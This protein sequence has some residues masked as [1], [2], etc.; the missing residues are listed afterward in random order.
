MLKLINYTVEGGGSVIFIEY[1]VNHNN[2]SFRHS[3]L[4]KDWILENYKHRG[5]NKENYSDFINS[6]DVKHKLTEEHVINFLQWFYYS[7]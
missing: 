4:F 3:A 1:S 2:R 5:I 6:L 7:K